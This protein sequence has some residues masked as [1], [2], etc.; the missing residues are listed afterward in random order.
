M[1]VAIVKWILFMHAQI[2]KSSHIT[3]YLSKEKINVYATEGTNE[4]C[5]L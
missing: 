5:E 4:I 1:G 2:Y 3:T